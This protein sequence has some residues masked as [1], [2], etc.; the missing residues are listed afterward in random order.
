MTLA[1]PFLACDCVELLMRSVL[2]PP[3]T[4]YHPKLLLECTADVGSS[5][6]SRPNSFN[7]CSAF[8][9][10][11]HVVARAALTRNRCQGRDRG[12]CRWRPSRLEQWAAWET[13]NLLLGLTYADC[14]I[15]QRAVMGAPRFAQRGPAHRTVLPAAMALVDSVPT[16]ARRHAGASGREHGTSGEPYEGSRPRTQ[17]APLRR[18]A[19]VN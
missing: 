18:S 16:S 19:Y 12:R 13:S 10:D 2:H 5:R 6:D 9:T 4:R 1:T 14:R 7:K 8:P 3:L 15:P 17:L 11:A